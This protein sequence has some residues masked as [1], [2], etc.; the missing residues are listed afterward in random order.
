MLDRPLLLVPGLYGVF[1]KPLPSLAS[2]PRRKNELLGVHQL[3]GDGSRYKKYC[4][5]C[6][7][8]HPHLKERCGFLAK[9]CLHVGCRE[10]AR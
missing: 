3:R 10:G 5:A 1:D 8:R 9:L 4:A 2:I 7:K 6:L